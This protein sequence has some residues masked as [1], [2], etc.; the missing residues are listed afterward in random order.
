MVS[1][2]TPKPIIER[3][4]QAAVKAQKDP[5]YQAI[6]KKQGATAGES[7][8]E[9]FAKLIKSDAAKWARVI[10]QAGIKMQ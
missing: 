7:G 2:K 9:S 3:L 5:H 10:K 6:L 4:Q 1:S 8:P